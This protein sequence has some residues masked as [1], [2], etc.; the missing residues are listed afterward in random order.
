MQSVSFKISPISINWNSIFP[1]AQIRQWVDEA[2]GRNEDIYL[3]NK[4]LN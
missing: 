1:I 2:I 3:T 4:D